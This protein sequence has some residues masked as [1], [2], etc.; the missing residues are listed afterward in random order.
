MKK[1]GIYCIENKFNNKKYIGQARDLNKREYEHLRGLKGNYHFNNYLQKAFNKYSQKGF[2]FKVIE[3]CREELLDEK[4]MFYIEKFN[5]MDKTKGYNLRAGGHKPR[6]SEISKSKISS[7]RIQRI[8]EGQIVLGGYKYTEEQKE[9]I[10]KSKYEFYKNNPKFKEGLSEL[11]A[12]IS[13]EEI[14][15]IK[16]MLYMDMDINEIADIT[17]VGIN[18]ITHIDQGNTFQHILP[19]LNYYIKNRYVINKQ[20]Q[21]SKVLKEYREG[22]TYSQ[23]ASNNNIHIR[24]AIRIVQGHKTQFDEQMRDK[25]TS[26]ELNKKHNMVRRMYKNGWTTVKISKHYKMSRNTISEILNG[27]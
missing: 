16:T 1:S 7:T 22:L 3:E 13:I 11:K 12:T 26:Y 10:S 14:K 27:E 24:T 18:I 25:A 9:K 8:K 15:K 17:E 21:I 4:E 5:T 19:K 6:L 2:E 20:R 23:I